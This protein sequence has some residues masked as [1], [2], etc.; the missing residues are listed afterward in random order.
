MTTQVPSKDLS[1][2][3]RCWADGDH[4][5]LR[6]K[7]ADEIERLE[8]QVEQLEEDLVTANDPNPRASHEPGA[9]RP[10]LERAEEII[11]A[12]ETPADQYEPYKNRLLDALRD[13]I[14]SS[15]TKEV[16]HD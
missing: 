15:E 8:R 2:R 6:R 3:L 16:S 10:G 14:Y 13:A 9:L 11:S 4:W 7:A 1:S 12:I 5:A